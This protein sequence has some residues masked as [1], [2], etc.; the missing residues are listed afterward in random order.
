MSN[1]LGMAM[2]GAVA[3]LLL[4][5]AVREA[6]VVRRLQ[7][8]GIRTQGVVVDNTRDDY[9]DGHNWVPVIAFVDQQGHRVEFS[10]RMRGT[11][12]N[13]ARGLEVQVVYERGKPQTAR[14]LMWKH[15]MGPA[16]YMLL[17]AVAFAGAGVLIALKS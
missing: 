5:F 7:R 3:L 13:L 8:A 6:A 9:S 10:P 17:S 11:G 4:G 15:M 2:C 14:V 12:M 16:V 1:S